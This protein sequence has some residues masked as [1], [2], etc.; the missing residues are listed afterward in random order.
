M[1]HPPRLAAGEPSQDTARY[2]AEVNGYFL[3]DRGRF[4]YEFVNA[5]A[6]V[7]KPLV[8]EAGVLVP[9]TQDLALERTVAALKDTWIIGIGS[10]RASLETNYALLDLVGPDNF[11]L[12]TRG[13]ELALHFQMRDTLASIGSASASPRRAASSDAVLVLGEDVWNT[14]PILGL[15]LRQASRVA[16]LEKHMREKRIP[17]WDDASLREAIQD[18]RGPF[19][20]ATSSPCELDKVAQASYRAAPDDLARL[21]FA[22][23]R[24]IDPT[25]AEPA[26]LPDEVRLLA[27]RIAAALLAAARP[28]VVSGC[29]SGSPAV[30]RAAAAVHAAL[31]ARN[32][33]AALALVFPR[34]NSLGAS[35]LLRQGARAAARGVEAAWEAMQTPGRL[36][37]IVAEADLSTCSGPGFDAKK[38]FERADSLIVID[39]S[40]SAT[41]AAADIVL[42]SSAFAESSG[43][44][45]SSEGRAQRFFASYNAAAPVREAWKWLDELSAPRSLDQII[46]AIAEDFPSLEPVIRAAPPASFR[47]L[48]RKVAR[49]PLR[50]SGR[51][52]ATAHINLREPKPLDDP[53]SFLSHSMEGYGG[54][55][56]TPQSAAVARYWAPGWNSDQAINKFQDEMGGASK[57]GDSGARLFDTRGPAPAAAAMPATPPAIPA[58]FERRADALLLVPRHSSLGCE[59]LS[60]RSPGLL[61]RAGEPCLWIS[62]ADAGPR[63]LVH[64]GYAELSLLPEGEGRLPVVKVALAGMPLGVASLS[65]GFPA[66]AALSLTSWASIHAAPA[67]QGGPR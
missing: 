62:P 52:A 44:Y 37:L 31:A 47:Y 36:C 9:A 13:E 18:E 17:R 30:L 59:E 64:G 38:L 26:A 3:C 6:R 60:A 25:L 39:H 8:R 40:Q 49:A 51:T 20:V 1:Q 7:L 58:A 53:D 11:F 65:S 43:T 4:G 23:A 35:L 16:P 67:P 24:E 55:R 19:F 42:P 34:A 50:E 66:Q 33:A 5:E 61:A 14:A 32:A 15:A 2:N 54:F 22:V 48:G 29:E 56:A 28:L 12:A 41:T 63:G 27:A 46:A 10:E 57:G 45:V 21:G